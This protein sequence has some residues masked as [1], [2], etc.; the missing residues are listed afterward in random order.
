MELK[1]K[2][3]TFPEMIEFNHEE[4]KK[5]ISEKVKHYASLVYSDEQIKDAKADRAKLNKF[6]DALETKR[7]EIKKQCLAPYEEFEKRMK[8]IV[9]I[10][11]EPI[12]LIDKQIKS[13]EEKKREDKLEEINGYWSSIYDQLPFP[14][15]FDR[16]FNEKWL[17]ASVKMSTIEAEIT[18]KIQRISADI[19]TL[20]KMP[21]FS[22][23]AIEVYKETLDI[24]FAIQEG[25]KLADLQKK[26]AEAQ[27]EMMNSGIASNEIEAEEAVETTV[28]QFSEAE[29]EKNQ[30][31]VASRQWIGFRALL[32]VS[33]AKELAN[34]FK[35][36]GIQYEPITAQGKGA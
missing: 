32:S 4:I 36:R 5:E 23:E 25:Q 7:K 33:E 35:S 30:P 22:F 1:V 17:N 8:E 27:A 16:I 24:N 12:N 6:V 11:N 26:K 14:F 31:S 18:E 19:L 2:D 9:A 13:F 28:Q 20:E 15:A 21:E 3:F 10:V 34:F 29:N